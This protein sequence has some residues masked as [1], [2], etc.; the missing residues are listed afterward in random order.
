MVDGTV[1]VGRI[2]KGRLPE[3]W[4]WRWFLQTVPAPPPNQGTADTLDEAKAGFKT[5]YAEVRAQ[6]SGVRSQDGRILLPDT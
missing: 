6:G 4:K 1:V 5:R 3:G 2:Y